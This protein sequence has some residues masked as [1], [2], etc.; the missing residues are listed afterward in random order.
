MDVLLG[1]LLLVLEGVVPDE[2]DGVDVVLV[3][4]DWE[5]SL[6]EA[7]GFEVILEEVAAG[8]ECRVGLALEVGAELF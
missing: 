5:A 2:S 6:D 3:R 7:E 8:C 1:G 4:R